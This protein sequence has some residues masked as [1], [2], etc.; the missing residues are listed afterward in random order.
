MSQTKKVLVIDDDPIVIM[1]AKKLAELTHFADEVLAFENGQKALNFFQNQYDKQT[2]YIVFLD[3]NM[4]VLNG[5]GFL[6][7]IAPIC[8]T[9]NVTVFII[10]SSTEESD[11]EKANLNP[12]VH[13][14]IAKPLLADKLVALKSHQKIAHLFS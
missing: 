4:P 11:L 10:T 5:W 1:M 13:Q 14:Y 6:A 12:F 9:E 3:L 2:H 7:A 8:S